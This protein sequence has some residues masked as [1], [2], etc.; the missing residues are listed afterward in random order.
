M[1]IL[2]NI[3]KK[4]I[5]GTCAVCVFSDDCVDSDDMVKCWVKKKRVR[6]DS[7]CHRFAD[8]DTI[9]GD[10]FPEGNAEC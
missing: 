6:K 3:N 4:V 7:R 2:E 5:V 8:I 10:D 9:C 1:Y